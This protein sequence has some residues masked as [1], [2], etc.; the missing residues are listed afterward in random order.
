MNS[1]EELTRVIEIY[2]KAFDMDQHINISDCETISNYLRSLRDDHSI[3]FVK[4]TESV[5]KARAALREFKAIL[6][7][8]TPRK[9]ELYEIIRLHLKHIFNELKA[10]G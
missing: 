10:I 7:Q 6:T 4:K 5:D 9:F 3:A 8:T 1:R 2:F